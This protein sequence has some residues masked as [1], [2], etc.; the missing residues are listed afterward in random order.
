M[1]ETSAIAAAMADTAASGGAPPGIQV[2]DV[3]LQPFNPVDAT[4]IEPSSA[5]AGPQGLGRLG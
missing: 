2:A 3:A 4:V 1:H 5:R